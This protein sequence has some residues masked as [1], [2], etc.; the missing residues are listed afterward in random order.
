MEIV[1]L[2]KEEFDEY[3]NNHPNKN[4]YQTS[5]YGMLMD[6]HNFDDYYLAMKDEAGN[7][8]AATLILINKVFFGYKWGYC[9]RGFL[10]DYNNFELLET[11]TKLLK[12]YLNKR[13]FM[14]IKIDPQI[15]NKSRNNDGLENGNIDNSNII[16][17]LEQLGYE[18]EGYNLNF[19]T[20]KPRWNAVI[21]TNEEEDLF[22]RYNKEIK[23]KIRK[24][25]KK[26]IEVIRGTDDSVKQF[27]S[28][29]D[30]KQKRK[31]NY[32]LD[33]MEIMGKND[34]FEI[35]FAVLNTAK[36]I[37]ISQNLFEEEEKRNNEINQELEENI[38]SNNTSN[39]IR[40]KMASDDILNKCKQNIISATNLYKQFPDGLIIGANA[41]IKYNNE[42][43][44]LIDGYRE[45]FKNYC[46]N[47]YLKFQIIEK[48]RHE[49]Y[50]RF[51]LNGI[52][53]D[54]K[55]KENPY[56][57]LSRFKL[58]FAAEIEEYIGEFTLIINKGKFATFDK[59]N[60]IRVW[61][62]E[63]LFKKK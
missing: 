29:I 21:N 46:P 3:A 13:N 32:Y 4:F 11:F 54:L 2:L 59:I 60:P 20:F 6:R 50:N 26:G 25:E 1:Q 40:R 37:E 47:H 52:T 16:N 55:N 31:L 23:N 22:L 43:F 19:E 17:E 10:I 53:G 49:G 18:H 44:F 12:E 61:L 9:P 56:Y 38:N 63:P 51:N 33:M 30:K 14:F 39:I 41:I 48:Y 35:Y 42:I 28:L 36:Y 34:M 45:D 57:G 62:N 24:A 27:Y 15:I 8:K 58:G 7:I 5:S